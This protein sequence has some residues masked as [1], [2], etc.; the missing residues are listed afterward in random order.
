MHDPLGE[1]LDANDDMAQGA[2]EPIGE[3]SQY[4]IG[5]QAAPPPTKSQLDLLQADYQS[6]RNIYGEQ[7]AYTREI[8]REW[9]EQ[10]RIFYA[11]QPPEARVRNLSADIRGREQRRALK[12]RRLEDLDRQYG[13]AEAAIRAA[14][15]KC[16]QI[17]R[18]RDELRSGMQALDA[19]IEQATK[20]RAQ[21][22]QEAADGATPPVGSRQAPT[23][24][25]DDTSQ[26][27]DTLMALVEGRP[28]RDHLAAVIQACRATVRRAVRSNQALGAAQRARA[29]F[30]Q[31]RTA[32]AASAGESETYE[33]GMDDGGSGALSM[34]AN[35]ERSRRPVTTTASQAQAEAAQLLLDYPTP[36]LAV[37][38]RAQEPPREDELIPVPVQSQPLPAPPTV[39]VLALTSPQPPTAPSD[40]ALAAAVP[41][42]RARDARAAGQAGVARHHPVLLAAGQRRSSPGRSRDRDRRRQRVQ[43]GSGDDPTPAPTP[44]DEDDGAH[45]G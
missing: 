8:R 20:D 13:E 14:E 1:G 31:A 3:A 32:T 22:I 34:P 33:S 10:K 41:P 36:V 37:R 6:R 19:Q 24:Q 30:M 5:E 28:D 25:Q 16:E 45:C 17:E 4:F 29:A 44:M 7:H 26:A 2:D 15:E 21:A 35:F 23:A 38:P 43:D 42:V 9:E 18:S 11:S 12:K 40:A 27:L 39:P